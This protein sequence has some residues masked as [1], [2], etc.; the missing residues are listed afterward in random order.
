MSALLELA[1]V[2][3]VARAREA[4]VE[5]KISPVDLDF[6]LSLWVGMVVL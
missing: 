3:A 2:Q 4:F 5:A 1:P 6:S